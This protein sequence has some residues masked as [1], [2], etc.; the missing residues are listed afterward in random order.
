MDRKNEL[1]DKRKSA[2]E[3]IRERGLT[4]KKPQPQTHR[5]GRNKNMATKKIRREALARRAYGTERGTT[6]NGRRS[7][8]TES[9]NNYQKNER[10]MTKRTKATQKHNNRTTKINNL[11]RNYSEQSNQDESEKVTDSATKKKELSAQINR[12]TP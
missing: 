5:S 10:H 8:E 11:P 6:G 9:G 4:T 1:Q 3:L 12:L 7:K 2:T